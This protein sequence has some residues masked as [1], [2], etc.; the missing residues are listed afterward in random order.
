MKRKEEVLPS[1]YDQDYWIWARAPHGRR[2]PEDPRQRRTLRIRQLK[3]G[4]LRS[5]KWLVFAS[6]E[7]VDEVWEKI[8]EATEAGRLGT[9]AKVR[10]AMP[11]L[12]EPP[13][14]KERRVICVYTRDWTDEQD[15][16]RV[17]E[18]LGKLGITKEIPY[19]SDEDTLGGKYA[20]MGH[21]RI[22]KYWA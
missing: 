17:R 18:E 13:E 11:H 2:I 15:V 20:V 1:T 6:R 16:M 19:K 7:N 22:A 21:K 3:E 14:W 12:A 4:K 9:S 8:R 10:T 5:G